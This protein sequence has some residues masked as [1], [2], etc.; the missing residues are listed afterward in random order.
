MPTLTVN[1]DGRRGELLE[2]ARHLAVLD[3]LLDVVARH[4]GGRLML[5]GGEA[6]VGKTSLL[7]RFG[8]DRPQS[9]RLLW[10]GC[11]PL[12]TPRPLGPLFDI[13][14]S[15]G[16][17]L[18]ELVGGGA[19]PHQVAMALIRE[20][21]QRAP[22]VLVFDDMHWAD[23]AT[24][25]VLRLLGRRIDSVPALVVVSYR[26]DQL[27]R[28]HPLR[29]VFGELG[30]GDAISRL[31]IE[32]LSSAAVAE[33]AESHGVD[34]EALW[35][36]T[37]GNS[38]FVTEVLAAGAQEI[39]QS[40]RDAVLA[41]AARLSSRA[42]S[43]LEAVAIVPE[44]AELW[45]LGALDGESVD[46][47]EEC[48]ASGMLL[49]SGAAVAF[50]HELARLT[51]EESLAPDRRIAL[52][53]SALAALAASPIGAVDLDRLSHHAEAACDGDAV[54]RFAPAAA[55]RAASAGAHREAAAQYRRALRYADGLSL[56]ARAELLDRCARECSLIGEMTE[57]I[58]L[59]QQALECHRALGAPLGEANSARAMSW[60]LWVVARRQEA[61]DAALRA[62][63]LLEPLPA[64]RELAQAYGAL[65]FLCAMAGDMEG[66]LDWGT[67]AFELAQQLDDVKTEVH[68]LEQ[69]GTAE[70]ARGMP[71]GRKKLERSLELARRA[72]LETEVAVALCYL[73]SGAARA[74]AYGPAESY[75]SEGI[76]YCEKR[77][78]EGWRPFLIAVRAE[79]ELD[80]GRWD[81]AA[82]L[83]RLV[84]AGQGAGL[85]TVFA[86][87]VVGRLGARRGDSSAPAA[88]D[89]AQALAEPSE[90]LR[91][92]GRVAAGRAEAA[93]LGGRPADVAAATDV[94]FELA[95]RRQIPSFIGELAYWRWRAGI[96][97]G[98]PPGVP[99]LCAVE[100]GGDWRRAAAMWAELGCPYEAA[101]ALADADD[102]ETVRRA[103]EQLQRLGAKP[104]A[105]IIAQRL[106]KRGAHGLPRGPRPTTRQHVANL[107]SR[108]QE[109]LELVAQGLR[110]TEIAERLFLSPRT[111]EHHV[112]ALLS[113]LNVRSR[114][115][116]ADA[117]ARLGIASQDT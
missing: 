45:L 17:E 52:H 21:A 40:V 112:S 28:L 80:Q 51:I 48:L 42:R 54:Q 25:D 95:Q 8:E 82:E 85:A 72:G 7:R 16:G 41:R 20:L 111:V 114:D 117:A 36:V 14:A 24:L 2:R 65:A 67:R 83:A 92:I 31:R 10:G 84:L 91:R 71:G 18:D 33:L 107:T 39:P 13:A 53:R 35:R 104:A 75:A 30:G 59:R 11:D 113:K 88:L 103:L 98:I 100:L 58:E 105:A 109:V 29:I 96:R 27:D 9:V 115:Q 56:D 73:A 44:Q 23:G 5:V 93:W 43:L 69:I 49:S 79:T 87:V 74:R 68:A 61:V 62:V 106:R 57:A 50:R 89:N 76:D 116:A 78:L 38:F 86:L 15:T 64:G 90:E 81:E 3:G 12:L 60:P 26:D 4:S 110:N 94:A 101:L 70:F 46:R 63:A 37:G 47:L 19:R 22:T 102:H 34:G 108:E 77:D 55:V 32:S 97:E 1:D 6:G 99:E 66:T